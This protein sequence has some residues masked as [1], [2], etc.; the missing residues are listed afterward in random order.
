MK[1]ISAKIYLSS[2]RGIAESTDF[3]RFSTFNFE[4]YNHE[5]KQPFEGLCMCND[6]FIAG[7]KLTF[8]LSKEN[9]FHVFV[10]ITGGLDILHGTKEYAVETENMQVLFLEKGEVL[11]ISN[12]YPKDTVNYLHLAFK[13]DFF[14]YKRDKLRFNF[15]F[16][17]NNNQ[18]LEVINDARFP[19]KVSAGIFDGRTDI[20]YSLSAQTGRC[21]CFV[22]DGAF[23][24]A[25][26]LLHPRD[27]LALWDTAKVELET[28]S[29]HAIILLVELLPDVDPIGF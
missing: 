24:V 26:C 19:F 25:G 1:E 7:G 11:E 28:L 13:T 29:N 14:L 12:P 6:E 18:L 4:R 8:F 15:D 10:P 27:G 17:T 22:I 23:E 3:K 20:D 2:E 9:S 5:H 21:F 16:K